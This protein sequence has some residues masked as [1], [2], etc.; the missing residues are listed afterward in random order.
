MIHS[1]TNGL[2]STFPLPKLPN[3]PLEAWRFAFFSSFSLSRAFRFRRRTSNEM[4]P[5]WL[6]MLRLQ[7]AENSLPTSGAAKKVLFSSSDNC[8]RWILRQFERTSHF[9][10][11]QAWVLRKNEKKNAKRV[12]KEA[13]FPFSFFHF[14]SQ[15]KTHAQIYS[16]RLLNCY[17][18]ENAEKRVKAI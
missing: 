18:T 5:V 1:I 13:H 16:K 15:A 9:L 6:T 8:S 10:G 14:S 7:A 12:V 11:I 4:E 2:K 17:C 3:T